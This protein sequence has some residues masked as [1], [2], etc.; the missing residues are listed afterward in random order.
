MKNPPNIIVQLVHIQGPLKGEIQEFSEPKI[1]IGRYPQCHVHFPKDLVVVSREHAEIVREGNR[2]KIIDKSQNGTFVN[3]KRMKE[4][5][6]K[7]GD[8]LTFAEGGPKVSFLTNMVEGEPQLADVPDPSPPEKTEEWLYEKPVVT[9]AKPDVGQAEKISIQR[10]QIPLVIQYGPTL[11]SFKELPVTIGKAP[12][13]DILLEHPGILDRHAEI[14]FSQD[15]Y[16]VRDLTGQKLI[17]VNGQHVDLQTPL[18][19]EDVLNLSSRGP[20]F[21]FM[22]GGRLAEI[23]EPVQAS[24]EKKETPSEGENGRKGPT[25]VK[26]IFDK[27]LRH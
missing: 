20:K 27:F 15:Q 23:E 14:F 7:D 26:S 9:Q 17:S 19:P 21:R 18:H 24:H 6:L 11:R 5:Y 1:S 8:V 2:F 3:G 10:V 12:N 4:A 25:E 16:W 22:A 13:C